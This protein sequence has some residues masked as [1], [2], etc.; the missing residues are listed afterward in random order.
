[1]LINL[2]KE[3]SGP[4]LSARSEQTRDMGVGV[5]S[6]LLIEEDRDMYLAIHLALFTG[7]FL[8]FAWKVGTC[9]FGRNREPV[10]RPLAGPRVPDLYTRQASRRPL[11]QPSRPFPGSRVPRDISG[12]NA[13][14]PVNRITRYLG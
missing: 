14:Q 4:R 3:G 8:L 5:R 12:G 2:R 1:M 11:A 6:L 7:A 9:L 10:P 13:Y